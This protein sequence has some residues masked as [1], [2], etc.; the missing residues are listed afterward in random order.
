MSGDIRWDSNNTT[1][2]FSPNESYT[3]SITYEATLIFPNGKQIWQFTT[4]SSEIVNDQDA[5]RNQ[6]ESDIETAESLK[7]F[8]ENYP[9]WEKFP[10][11]K[12]SYFVYFHPEK[13]SFI[14][15]LYPKKGSHSAIDQEVNVMKNEIEDT[16]R[17]LNID[18]SDFEIQ[19]KVT[20]EP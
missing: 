10:L 12:E 13:K 17:S 5:L 6:I 9:W 8:Y 20:P 15:H 2:I 3:P 18:L 4:V 14:G 19:W 16:F 7:K 1:I 11:K